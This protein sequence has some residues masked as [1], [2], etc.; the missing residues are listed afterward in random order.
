[1]HAKAALVKEWLTDLAGMRKSGPCALVAPKV[2]RIRAGMSLLFS[3]AFLSYVQNTQVHQRSYTG[4]RERM[5][6]KNKFLKLNGNMTVPLR[7][8]MFG[9][10]E[11]KGIFFEKTPSNEVLAISCLEHIKIKK[12]IRSTEGVIELYHALSEFDGLRRPQFKK[13]K[14]K[15]QSKKSDNFYISGEWRALRYR[16]L[17]ENDGRCELCGAGKHSGATLH[18]D[19]IMPRSKFPKLELEI[20]NLQILCADCNMGK[21]NKDTTDWRYR[22]LSN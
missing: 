14:S 18:V 7:N 12:P 9:F 11:S 6:K 15:V 17:K 22:I 5:A 2:M 19:H 21:S 13:P 4:V 3:K 20:T 10:L 1:M 8:R 16:A